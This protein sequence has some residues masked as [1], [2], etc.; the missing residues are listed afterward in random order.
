MAGPIAFAF[1]A[2]ATADAVR[3]SSRL[4]TAAVPAGLPPRGERGVKGRMVAHLGAA[5]LVTE[6]GSNGRRSCPLAE[7]TSVLSAIE[8]IAVET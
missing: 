2:A 3:I 5:A 4:R 1:A 6:P 7:D 8:D